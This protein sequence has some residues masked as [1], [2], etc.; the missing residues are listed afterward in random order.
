MVLPDV[1]FNTAPQRISAFA[2]K[3]RI[4]AFGPD[5]PFAESGSLLSYGPSR[6]DM[7]RRAATYVKKILGTADDYR[8]LYGD[9]TTVEGVETSAK[10]VAATV[11][12]PAKKAAPLRKAPPKKRVPR[13]P[14]KK[15]LG[16]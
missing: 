3:N 8:R 16:R 6:P 15:A 9:G 2:L 11:S 5:V 4:A 10:P 7:A 14:A 13:K 12:A 1:I